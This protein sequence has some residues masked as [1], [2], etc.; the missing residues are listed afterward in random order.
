MDGFQLVEK[1][2]QEETLKTI[3]VIA[4]SAGGKDAQ[5]RAMA[6]GVDIFLRKPVK[7]VEVLETV[8]TL[9]RIA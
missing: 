8:K 1:I 7:F 4:I 5:E 3:P 6:A 2:R 9:L